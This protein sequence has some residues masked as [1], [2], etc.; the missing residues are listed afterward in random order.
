[1]IDLKVFDVEELA[2]AQPLETLTGVYH[3]CSR[4]TR[5]DELAFPPVGRNTDG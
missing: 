1:M 4:A 3:G 5:L 2:I